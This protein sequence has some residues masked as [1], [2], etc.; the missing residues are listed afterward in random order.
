MEELVVFIKHYTEEDRVVITN[1]LDSKEF[2]CEAY[3]LDVIFAEVAKL[4]SRVIK[5]D[6]SEEYSDLLEY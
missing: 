3:E 6:D 2:K 1:S 5:Y 4:M